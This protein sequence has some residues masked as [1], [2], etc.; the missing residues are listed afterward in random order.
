MRFNVPE[1]FYMLALVPALAAQYGYSFKRKIAALAAYFDAGVAARLVSGH[2]Q[3]RQWLK[4][5]AV[6]SAVGLLV[7]SLMQPQWG[8]R[9]EDVERKGRDVIFILDVSLSML[10][11]D[12]APSRLE[13]A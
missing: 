3:R 6:V 9:L 4:A 13:R 8:K 11:E 10:A 1:Y 7:G 12:A 2:G 5:L